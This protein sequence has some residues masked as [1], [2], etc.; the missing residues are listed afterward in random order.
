[1]PISRRRGESRSAVLHVAEEADHPPSADRRPALHS[2]VRTCASNQWQHPVVANWRGQLERSHLIA[3]GNRGDLVRL[4]DEANELDRTVHLMDV[5][6]RAG[7]NTFLDDVDRLLAKYLGALYA[8]REHLKEKAVDADYRKQALRELRTDSVEFALFVRRFGVH[9]R[10]PMSLANMTITSLA[11]SGAGPPFE[12][13][14]APRL[15]RADLVTSKKKP[16]PLA[17]A[18]LARHDED[19]PVREVVIDSGVAVEVS[20]ELLREV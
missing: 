6:N 15:I 19:I 5:N 2:R 16:L 10:P 8:L 4:L 18:Y 7:L 9:E 17:A 13:V 11:G 3:L 12:M 20:L 1:M 14:L